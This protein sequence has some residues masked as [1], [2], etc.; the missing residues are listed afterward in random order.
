MEQCASLQTKIA[1]GRMQ[2]NIPIKTKHCSADTASGQTQSTM[3]R[4]S[5]VS[6]TKFAESRPLVH[7][8]NALNAP[9][10]REV[11]I[12]SEADGITKLTTIAPYKN[13]YAVAIAQAINPDQ[14]TGAFLGCYLLTP[15]SPH[16][17]KPLLLHEAFAAYKRFTNASS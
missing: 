17:D 7:R 16:G 12:I 8:A 11:K 10:Q 2:G 4:T 9:V 13:G 5:G 14:T 1:V 6:L 15:E 3:P